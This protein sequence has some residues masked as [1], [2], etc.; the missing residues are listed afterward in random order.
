VKILETK[1][2]TKNFGGLIAVNNLS[3]EIEE[4]SITGLIG[5]NGSGKTTF[6]NLISGV[7]TVTSGQIFFKGEDITGLEKH[8]IARLG[9]G[10]TFQTIRLFD[11]LTVLENV[12]V[13]RHNSYSS[14]LLD[15]LLKTSKLRRE[16]EREQQKA[17]ELLDLVG[18][19]KYADQL[20][21][22]LPYGYRRSLEIARALSLEPTLL[23]LD[24][25]AAGMNRDEFIRLQDIIREINEH[26]ITILL[27]EHTM[28]LVEA[29][30]DQVIVLDYGKKLASGTFTEIENNPEVIAA[31]LGEEV[32]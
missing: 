24:E 15:A 1:G 14:G 27:V 21:T 32:I 8:E 9:I 20:P 5:P 22:N 31:Y 4:G 10:R 17:M 7:F 6:I 29:V 3:I 28:E 30:V 25:P 2:L 18:L 13:G 26:K 23:L 16:E 19:K 12:L 11:R